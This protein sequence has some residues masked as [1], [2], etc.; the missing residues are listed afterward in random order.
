MTLRKKLDV[1]TCDERCELFGNWWRRCPTIIFGDDG[2]CL[3]QSFTTTPNF[4]ELYTAI[5]A[6]HFG[7]SGVARDDVL[8][9]CHLLETEF[10]RLHH[11][12]VVD[13]IT[14]TYNKYEVLRLEHKHGKH[15]YG[16]TA[17]FDLSS[18]EH[19]VDTS[20]KRRNII[21]LEQACII[22]LAIA[23]GLC[24]AYVVWG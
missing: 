12:S 16:Y 24:A 14:L 15:S 7:S 17:I 1:L 5:D 19:F 13:E 6:H 2:T 8:Y 23:F 22:P 21:A 18:F 10:N 9:I 20:I 3:T 11:M 4:D